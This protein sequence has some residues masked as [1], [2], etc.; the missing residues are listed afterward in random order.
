M[1][2]LQ[3]SSIRQ[4][5]TAIVMLAT[6]LALFVA[7]LVFIVSDQ[8]ITRNEMVEKLTVMPDI[9]GT[10]STAAIIFGIDEDASEILRSL[11]AEPNIITAHIHA[12]NGREIGAYYRDN[13]S[14]LGDHNW[15][16]K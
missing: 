9:I 8:I 13:D 5:L 7:C 15:S 2:F 4:K 16:L 11:K 12:L 10:N 6:F 3:D 14:S 1:R